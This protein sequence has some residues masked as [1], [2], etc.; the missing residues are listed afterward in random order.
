MES[1]VV[2]VVEVVVSGVEVFVIIRDRA[3]GSPLLTSPPGPTLQYQS[4]R[5]F[6]GLMALQVHA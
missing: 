5:T 4:N 3:D 1:V 6:T 2:V